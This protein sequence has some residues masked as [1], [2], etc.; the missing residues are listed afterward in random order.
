MLLPVSSINIMTP[1][2]QWHQPASDP[3]SLEIPV[4]L[5]ELLQLR[6]GRRRLSFTCGSLT[7]SSSTARQNKTKTGSRLFLGL[8]AGLF[9]FIIIFFYKF[10]SNNRYKTPAPL[11][12][13]ILLLSLLFLHVSICSPTPGGPG[14]GPDPG[15]DP[16]PDPDPAVRPIG[17][18][19]QRSLK[20]CQRD[21]TY[22]LKGSEPHTG[23]A[24]ELP[25][26]NVTVW[27]V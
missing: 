8:C 6:S 20:P 13:R 5:V 9:F 10:T 14:L 1:P 3:L 27:L 11:Y 22:E 24:S 26:Q 18:D 19:V 16:G 17:T 25:L 7:L 2:R 15:L 23:A 21:L 4:Q 12:Q